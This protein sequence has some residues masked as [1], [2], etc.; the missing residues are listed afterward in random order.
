MIFCFCK[1]SK[2]YSPSAQ[3]PAPSFLN[4]LNNTLSLIVQH[5]DEFDDVG[6]SETFQ[7]FNLLIF[8][9]FVQVLIA[10]FHHF[11]GVFMAIES[12]C[13]HKDLRIRSF[14]LFALD[15]I[16]L[17]IIRLKKAKGL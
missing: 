5:I 12:R 11:E 3:R 17:H 13:G 15:S 10:M 14:S 4:L 16:V 6:M 2:D 8:F 1:I 7:C 9:Y